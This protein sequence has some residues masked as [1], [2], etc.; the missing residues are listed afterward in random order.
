MKRKHINY[1]PIYAVVFKW[2][3]C[4]GYGVVL[5]SVA[6]RASEARIN[7]LGVR[8]W[9]TSW[10]KAYKDGYR[11]IRITIQEATDAK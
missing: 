3:N 5:G 4:K 10:K 7:F 8:G 11:C 6:C 1:D 2:D 9:N